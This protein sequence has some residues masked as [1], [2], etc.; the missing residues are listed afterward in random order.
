MEAVLVLAGGTTRKVGAAEP[1]ND[2]FGSATAPGP[3]SSSASPFDA[4]GPRL[5]DPRALRP[6]W[7]GRRLQLGQRPGCHRRHQGAVRC[8]Q[9]GSS[10]RRDPRRRAVPGKGNPDGS[11]VARAEGPGSVIVDATLPFAAIGTVDFGP[12][13]M[14][15]ATKLAPLL[16]SVLGVRSADLCHRFARGWGCAARPLRQAAHGRGP[17]QRQNMAAAQGGTRRERSRPAITS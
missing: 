5:S 3:T 1:H 16:P 15:K 13:A 14:G 8:H 12:L 2:G 9:R 4:G 6:P 17:R 7:S 10:D 11:P